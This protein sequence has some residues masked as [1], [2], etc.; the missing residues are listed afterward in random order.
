MG[1]VSLALAIHN[2][3][4]LGN[5]DFVFEEAYH[6]A[7][8]PFLDV[9]GQFPTIKI[10][11]H[12]SGI[13]F[14]WLERTYPEIIDNLQEMV[15]NGQVEMLGGGFYE[16]IL[17]MIPER[18]R[19]G[20]FRKLSAYVQDRFGAAP[21]G[22]WLAE[23]VWEPCFAKNL[24][25]AGIQY[26]LLDDIHF[27]YAGVRG[28]ELWGPYTTEDQGRRIVLFPIR[29]ELR[30][31]IPFQKPQKTIDFLR[32]LGD[33]EEH[34]LAVFGDDGEKFGIWP[35]TY[36]HVFEEGWLKG[37]LELLKKHD[38]EI[39]TVT[40][41]EASAIPS[42]GLIYLP[43]ASYSE[44]NHWALPT[45]AYL[46]FEEIQKRTEEEEWDE[47]DRAFV[48]GGVWRNFFAKY[49]EANRMH[50]KMIRLSERWDRLAQREWEGA[51]RSLLNE[52]RERIWAGQ[53]N[54]P[55][56]HGVFG[57]I[58]L[59]NIRFAIN[60][61][62]LSA[63]QQMDVLEWGDDRRWLRLEEADYDCDGFPEILVESANVN[64]YFDYTGDVVQL[65]YKEIPM[66][67]T[68]VMTRRREG[69]HRLLVRGASAE[70]TKPDRGE[71]EIDSIHEAVRVKEPGLEQ[72][73]Y[74]DADVRKSFV[75]RVMSSVATL[76]KVYQGKEHFERLTR[77]RNTHIAAPHQA[78][79]TCDATGRDITLKKEFI[80]HADGNL[81]LHLSALN[82]GRQMR[83]VGV[84]FNL[85]LL[86]GHADDRY[87]RIDGAKPECPHLESMGETRNSTNVAL[88]DHW[89]NVMMSIRFSRP[90]VLWR[91]P[92]ESIS[93]S[94]DGFERV[95]QGSCVLPVWE[96]KPGDPWNVEIQ[97]TVQPMKTQ[98]GLA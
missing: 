57:G 47:D 44:M 60:R 62:L 34:P 18:D 58:Y 52:S 92:V 71:D 20:Q 15:K 41:A 78:T 51:A 64:A 87:Y 79:I 61:S 13:L 77:I 38:D 32:R 63:E 27:R 36:E 12:Y 55:Y 5:F 39:E 23:R 72:K 50:K 28:E 22:A 91:Y 74:Y 94:E 46:R 43:T 8:R 26:T 30:Y 48:K 25:D 4:P 19:L 70:E 49:A 24:F 9:M 59:N 68:D 82:Q 93:L 29:K 88:M 14:E 89:Q 97:M 73:L 3:Q 16:P 80:V 75:V 53:C 81:V 95:Y 83:K 67:I 10:S 33:Q 17:S 11:L 54:C 84:E 2:H 1:K 7:Y 98:G 35:K 85:T 45:E 56:W 37:F 40:L 6:K 21:G 86:A 31:L 96:L 65:D 42:K 66:T 90:A 69:S 76:E